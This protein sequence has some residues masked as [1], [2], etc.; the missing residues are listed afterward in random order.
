MEIKEEKII[1]ISILIILYLSSLEN[2]NT[3]Y[4]FRK[5]FSIHLGILIDESVIIENLIEKGM[6]KSDGLIDKSPFYKSISC[7]EKG[8]KYYN[9]NIHKVKIIEDDFPGEKSDLV[10]IFLGLKRPS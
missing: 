4:R 6:L 1:D 8:K 7:T 2:I 5:I 10:K 3:S 9:D